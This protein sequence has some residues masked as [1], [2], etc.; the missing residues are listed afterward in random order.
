MKNLLCYSLL[1]FLIF[2]LTT[3]TGYGQVDHSADKIALLTTHVWY[4]DTTTTTS[5]HDD[6]LMLVDMY[7]GFKKTMSMSLAADGTHT[8][9]LM[10][11]PTEGTW[12]L[13]SDGTKLT[14]KNATEVNVLNIITLTSDVLEYIL[15]FGDEETGKHDIT[16]KW[17][18]GEHCS[19]DHP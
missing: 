19:W 10:G 18:K 2:T 12:E 3:L 4:C 14:L 9:M 8:M 15:S 6:I 17:V 11:S 1:S 16:F 13:S 5:T 7:E